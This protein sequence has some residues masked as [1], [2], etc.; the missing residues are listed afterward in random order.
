MPNRISK[1]FL[2]EYTTSFDLKHAANLV[3]GM[4]EVSSDGYIVLSVIRVQEHKGLG[5]VYDNKHLVVLKEDGVASVM[6]DS[7]HPDYLGYDE[8]VKMFAKRLKFDDRFY[9]LVSVNTFENDPELSVQE[10]LALPQENRRSWY[11]EQFLELPKKFGSGL[12]ILPPAF[13]TMA[14]PIVSFD[15]VQVETSGVLVDFNDED[16]DAI[17][18]LTP[19]FD[20]FGELIHPDSIGWFVNEAGNGFHNIIASWEDSDGEFIGGNILVQWNDGVYSVVS[21]N[22]MVGALEYSLFAE[23]VNARID[24]GTPTSILVQT[25]SVADA[26]KNDWLGD[27]PYDIRGWSIEDGF[28]R[29]LKED[30]IRQAVQFADEGDFALDHATFAEAHNLDLESLR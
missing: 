27:T 7:G 28:I 2:S 12:H 25:F 22:R 17:G 26:Q 30:E 10:N 11:V 6:G 16:G 19:N 23:S 29:G 14:N 1:A 5:L 18:T 4:V 21:D 20:E 24:D 15:G 9:T 8:F 13:Y 3:A